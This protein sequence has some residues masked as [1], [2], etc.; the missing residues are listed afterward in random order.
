MTEA[1]DLSSEALREIVIETVSNAGSKCNELR[2]DAD[3]QVDLRT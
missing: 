3:Q 2:F 1:V